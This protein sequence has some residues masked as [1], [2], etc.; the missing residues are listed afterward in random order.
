M[1]HSAICRKALVLSEGL[2]YKSYLDTKGYPTIG[3]GHRIKAN[4]KYLMD[5]LLTDEQVNDIFMKDMAYTETW[6]NKNCIWNIPIKQCEFD[7]LCCFLHQYNIEDIRFKDTKK[8]FISGDRQQ[9]IN[10]MM[11][12]RNA[13]AGSGDNQMVER[14]KREITMFKAGY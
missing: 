4:E 5:V 14:R 1:K 8:A 2:R 7:A 11:Q 6:I 12:F 10:Q 3:I 13:V 9:I